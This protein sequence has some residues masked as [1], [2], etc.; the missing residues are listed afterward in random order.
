MS[1]PPPPDTGPRQPIITPSRVVSGVCLIIPIVALL[2]VSS[3]SRLTPRFIGI[4]FFY[5]YQLL[6]VIITT[7][8]TAIAYVLVRREQAQR[9]GGAK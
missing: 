9:K 1:Q 4:P 8:L 6:W 5:W 7:G 2:W 3:Y